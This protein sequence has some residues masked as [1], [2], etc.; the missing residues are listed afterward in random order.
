M[1]VRT[2]VTVEYAAKLEYYI[3]LGHWVYIVRGYGASLN[4]NVALHYPSN[5]TTSQAVLTVFHLRGH[6]SS[7][8]SF[9]QSPV[10][11]CKN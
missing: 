5:Q 2:L 7:V 6:Q 9:L 1:K 8:T 11:H 4:I 10:N 3:A